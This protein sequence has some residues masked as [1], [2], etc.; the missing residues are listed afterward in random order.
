MKRKQ[1]SLFA[2]INPWRLSAYFAWSMLAL[3]IVA[4]GYFLVLSITHV[5][6]RE[7]LSLAVHEEEMR[8]ANLE[9]EYLAHVS[10]LSEEDVAEMGLVPVRSAGFVAVHTPAQVLTRAE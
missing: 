3:A 2:H 1:L 7:E 5:V 6:L 10:A 9:A 8:I 4:Y